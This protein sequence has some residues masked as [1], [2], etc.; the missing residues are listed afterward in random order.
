MFGLESLGVGVGKGKK[1]VAGYLHRLGNIE[2]RECLGSGNVDGVGAGRKFEIGESVFL[3]AENEAD[4]T[5]GS[6]CA[7]RGEIPNGV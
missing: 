6:R 4:D 2:G 1:F 3:V 7:K 5:V